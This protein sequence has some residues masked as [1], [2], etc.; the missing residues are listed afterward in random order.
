MRAA[1]MESPQIGDLIKILLLMLKLMLMLML[2]VTLRVLFLFK[3]LVCWW[4]RELGRSYVLLFLML[5]LMLRVRVRVFFS[6]PM[7]V[8]RSLVGVL[9]SGQEVYLPP[10]ERNVK[11]DSANGTQPMSQTL[12][13]TP[14]KEQKS[15]KKYWEYYE[16]T[17]VLSI[18]KPHRH[19]WT[20]PVKSDT[21]EWIQCLGITNINTSQNYF[22]FLVWF[23]ME[24]TIRSFI[25]IGRDLC[26]SLMTL[27]CYLTIIV[28]ED[29]S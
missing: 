12:C 20:L 6:K 16:S 14:R 2:M 27:L 25:V 5:T 10:P 29:E 9:C 24:T 8:L 7:V 3:L 1:S 17:R 19:F 26:H 21:S 18:G 13:F 28:L 22:D 11:G 15:S 4:L 23:E